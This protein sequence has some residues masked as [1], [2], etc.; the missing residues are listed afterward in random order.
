[1]DSPHHRKIELQSPADLTYLLNN[2][3]AS[4]AQKLDIAF[5][6]SAAPKDG[7][8]AVRAKVEQLV[9]EYIN[10]TFSLA[11]PSLSINGI[12][13]PTAY[14]SLSPTKDQGLRTEVMDDVD[15]GNYEPHDPRLSEKLRTLYMQHEQETTRVAE[16]RRDAPGAAARAFMERLRGE[17]QA[18]RNADLDINMEEGEGE[19]LRGLGT[20]ERK[21]DVERIWGRGVH[22]L[23][24]LE[25]VTGVIAKLE[26]A[27]KAAEV[28]EG[29]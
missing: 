9:N 4:A 22:G 6:P 28:V 1:M 5:P 20:L 11:L 17:M 12:D 15:D 19:A 25:E 3:R 18:E 23:K 26:R 10:E 21:E 16:L 8:D 29:M 27:A 2:I 24:G 7:E 13:G 14:P